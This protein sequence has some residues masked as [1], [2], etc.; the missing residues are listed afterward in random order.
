MRS[1]LDTMDL[2]YGYAAEE[3]MQQF[4][5][6]EEETDLELTIV[7]AAVF[8]LMV[9]MALF[10]SFTL[11]FLVLTSLPMALLGVFIIFWKTRQADRH[12]H[13]RARSWQNVRPEVKIW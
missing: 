11:P 12:H 8:I 13:L 2:P 1:I 6:E 7:L 3:S 5:T 10:E 4:L 9:L